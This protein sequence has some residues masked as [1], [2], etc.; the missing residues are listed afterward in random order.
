MSS[1]LRS[2]RTA[3]TGID[4]LLRAQLR[5]HREV[6]DATALMLN[7]PFAGI[8]E[9]LETSLRNGGKLL[10]FGNG[11]SA[12]DAQHF[13]AELLIRYKSARPA[14]AAIALTTDTS[15]LT[16]CG[17][18]MGFES[19]FARQIEGLGRVGDAAIGISTSGISGNVV[20]GLKQARSMG[21]K[22]VGLSGGTGGHMPDLCDALIIVPSAVTA[23]IQELHITICHVLCLALERRLGLVANDP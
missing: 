9:I 3:D 4:T 14:I 19:I 8:L 12:A 22:T 10:L 5:E 20:H 21:L 1:D 7:A 6:F 13:A 2:D 18:D 17:N 16:A 11:G 15:T 23:R